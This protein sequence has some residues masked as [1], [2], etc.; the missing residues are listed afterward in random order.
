MTLRQLVHPPRL[1]ARGLHL[2]RLHRRGLE[3]RPGR[4]GPSVEELQ[5]LLDRLS[6]ERQQ[7]RAE[8]ATPDELERN[9]CAITRAQWDLSHALIQRYLPDA[10]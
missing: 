10:A 6:A 9:R 1:H 8:H 5:R 4:V 2:R 7:L 3:R